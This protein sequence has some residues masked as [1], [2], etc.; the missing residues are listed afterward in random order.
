MDRAPRTSLSH[1]TLAR[2]RKLRDD[3][4]ALVRKDLVPISDELSQARWAERGFCTSQT[5]LT[6]DLIL[7]LRRRTEDIC[8]G[9]FDGA[10]APIPYRTPAGVEQNNIQM[11]S[12]VHWADTLI[13][14]IAHDHSLSGLAA[15]MLGSS[16]IRLWGT[17]LICKRG[18]ADAINDVIWHRDMTSWQCVSHPRLLTFW[19]A[20]DATSEANGCMEYALGSHL[21]PF[22]G[23]DDDLGRFER[24]PVPMQAGQV[25]AHHCLTG[26]RSNANRTEGPR[27]AIT[28]HFMD[29]DLHYVPGSPS[30][31]HINV[32]LQG[33]TV[34]SAFSDHYFP[35]VYNGT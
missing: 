13:S 10:K 15:R 6:A 1:D 23:N 17:S 24:V 9:H 25:S 31:D 8:R 29:G 5:A 2:A 27:R 32:W 20:L 35:L 19:I 11:Y 34:P 28:V 30:D 12:H 16:S 33:K 4:I 3:F 26:H 7:E 18:A 21:V 14:A 22:V